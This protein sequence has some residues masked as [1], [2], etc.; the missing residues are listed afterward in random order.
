MKNSVLCTTLIFLA[1]TFPGAAQELDTPPY[2]VTHPAE[3]I[4]CFCPGLHASP[5]TS[6]AIETD[7]G[8][9]LIDTGLSPSMGERTRARVTSHF[10]RD[11]IRWVINTH[12]HFDHS[13]GNQA[14]AD[15]LIVGHE[16]APA[17]MQAFFD[18]REAFIDRR[19]QRQARQEAAAARAEAGSD[20]ALSLEESLRFDSEFIEDLQDGY[21]ITPPTITFSDRLGLQA[22]DLDLELLHFGRAHTGS[23]ILTLVPS[24]KAGFTGDL[25]HED[26]LGVTAYATPFEVDRWLEVLDL[27]LSEE[28]DV[29]T[30]IG[31]HGLIFTPEW[32]GAQ[33]RYLGEVWSAVSEAKAT[34]TPLDDFTEALVFDDRFAYVVEQINVDT[35]ELENQ[36]AR[37][38]QNLWRIGQL[39]AAAEI[40]RTVRDSGVEA[41]WAQWPEIRDGNEFYVDEREFN[42]LGYE[43]L[44]RER[45]VPEALAVFEMNTQAFPESWNVWDSFAEAHWW[46]DDEEG[47]E[48]F[49]RK[50]LELN[51]EAES[52]LRA[53]SQIEG[54]RLDRAGET[55]IPAAFAPDACTGT[56]GPYLGQNLPGTQPEVFAPGIVST[57]DGF[58]FSISVS[59]DGR[60]IYFTRRLE[61]DGGNTLM[62]A[63]R[64]G[65][66][67]KAPKPA[68]FAAGMQANEPHITPD[69]SRLYFGSQPPDG[70]GPGIW[71]AERNDSGWEPPEFHGRGMFA[72]STLN[73]DLYMASFDGGGP[74]SIVVYPRIEDGWGGAQRLG[75]GVNE[76]RPGVHGWVAPDGGFIV[77]DSYQRSGAQG[78]EGDLFV[79]F[80]TDEGDWGE[81]LNLGDEINT[82]GTN[83]CPSL[84]P[85]G[86]ILFFS[87]NR[88]IYWVSSDVIHRL[89][90][91]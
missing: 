75:G 15:A 69:G 2:R 80:R 1:T 16:N 31:G 89:R 52:A 90:P 14:F 28:A 7:A 13:G 47:V 40:S 57:S 26:N 19:H 12:S 20:E 59:P 39:S 63:H 23:D 42:A 60:E 66:G 91:E 25:F 33:R 74:G 78:G 84:S 32:I 50:A 8:L 6:C 41:A 46:I 5:I 54:H 67:W 22:G 56:K 62:V 24:L 82:P 76:P 48:E 51:P 88:D 49:Y 55:R 73:G 3:R 61:P 79:A 18:G 34:D 21:S 83:F 45:K 87:T 44:T 86:K 72:S 71:V 81:A 17:E 53:I 68:P 77:F 4:T 38:L 30:F 64:C 36:H 37:N 43:L 27:A 9:V 65:E 11:D 29:E 70:R 58:E 10:G 85:D 35:A